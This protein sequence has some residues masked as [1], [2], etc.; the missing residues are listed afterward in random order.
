LSWRVAI[1]PFVEQ[2]ELYNKFKLDE[3]W[4]SPHNKELL[5]EMPALYRCPD[6]KKPEPF[7]TTY[8]GFV[9]PGTLLEKGQ[10]ITLADVTDGTSNTL[11]VVE[12]KEAVPWS[13]PDDLPFDPEAKPSLYGAGSP[14]PGGFNSG[15]ADGAVRFIKESVAAVV[16]RALITRAGGE[17][18]SSDAY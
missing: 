4:D 8:R 9:G 14:H 13:K 7:T 1:L 10:D 15:F 16:F 12:A 11:M 18:V 3:P 6:R 5:K 17:V 2:A